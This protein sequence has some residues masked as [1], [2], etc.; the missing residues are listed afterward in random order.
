MLMAE[1]EMK[2]PEPA[3]KELAQITF[4]EF[5]ENTPPGEFS[6]VSD[7]CLLTY[8][9]NR[10]NGY[11]LQKPEITLY[12]SSDIC[13][14]HRVFRY[15]GPDQKIGAN[16]KSILGYVIY[17]CSNCRRT[18]KTFSLHASVEKSAS[19]AGVSL[20]FGDV[21][22]TCYKFGEYPPYGP[23]M[24][25][26]LLRMF[27]KDRSFFLKGRQCENH[28][29]GIGAFVYYRRVVEN[30]KNQIL[31]EI[32]KVAKKM[33][34]DFVETLEAAKQEHQFSKALESVK[35]AIPQALLINGHNP[36]TLLYSALSEGLH[37]QTDEEC[38]GLA[39]DVRLVLA[40]LAERLTQALKDDA[41]LND[42]VSRLMQS[43]S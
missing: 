4:T 9:N 27:G 8:V 40:E 19:E 41:E 16:E 12:C 26:R 34:P 2:S 18:K 23:P 3:A 32:I 42:A 10:I 13:N 17:V 15:E 30:H 20:I 21:P 36:L 1:Q 22:G 38:L 35:D 37:A 29:L 14:G 11:V 28:G 31:D 33:A 24:S 43:K 39:H 6:K 5:L 25:N 7:L